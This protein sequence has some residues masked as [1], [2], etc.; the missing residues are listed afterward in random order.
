[1][2]HQRPRCRAV[3]QYAIAEAKDTLLLPP[4]VQRYSFSLHFRWESGPETIVTNEFFRFVI[5]GKAPES[6][7]ICIILPYRCRGRQGAAGM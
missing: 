3:P 1:M 2:S 6:P 5:D 7:Y 4:I